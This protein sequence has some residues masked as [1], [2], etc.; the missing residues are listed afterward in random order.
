MT[1]RITESELILPSLFLMS[2]NQGVITTS[3]LISKLREIMR[4]TGEDLSILA[5]RKDDKFSQKVRNLR[6][7]KTFEKYGYAKYQGGPKDG[8]VEITPYGLEHLKANEP[9]LNYLLI[10]DFTYKDLKDNLIKIEKNN[11]KKAIEIFDENIIIQEGTK[12]LTQTSVYERSSKL[13]NYAIEYYA[14]NGQIFCNCC[15]FNFNDFYGTSIGN[16]FI[17]IHHTKPIFKYQ[18]E[19]LERTLI[20][21]INNLIPVCSNCHRMIHRN[22][23]KP[24]EIQYLIDNI[25]ANGIYCRPT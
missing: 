15:N 17:E 10:N 18:D 20:E 19:D 1:N 6:A 12:K 4:P 24:L 13:R 21:A 16:G 23:K 11:N 3:E 8:Y 2:L 14:N 5:K 22:W 9:I 25:K 7:H